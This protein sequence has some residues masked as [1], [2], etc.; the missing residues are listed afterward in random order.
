MKD[1]SNTQLDEYIDG[2][3][4]V[5]RNA[6]SFENGQYNVFDYALNTELL[7]KTCYKFVFDLYDGNV[8]IESVSKY[9]IVR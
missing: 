1:Y 3:Y 9:I 5:S 4:Y 2:F 6:V 8:K 7:P